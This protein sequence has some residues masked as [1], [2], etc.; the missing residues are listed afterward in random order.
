M[1]NFVQA[2][3]EDGTAK[4]KNADSET[5]ETS[6]VSESSSGSAARSTLE[7]GDGAE[8]ENKE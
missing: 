5:E 4:N 1:A 2:S 7:S 3:E 6:E 8:D